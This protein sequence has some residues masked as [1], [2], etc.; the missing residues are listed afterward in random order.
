MNRFA[1]LKAYT[2]RY[3]PIYGTEDFCIYFY[4]L[5]KMRRPQRV[6]ELG[7]GIGAVAL[8]GALAL[9][10]NS[11][12]HLL[13]IDNGQ[14][15]PRLQQA[16]EP[17]NPFYRE[18]YV[19]Y[20]A[21][22][23]E[24]FQLPRLQFQHSTVQYQSLPEGIDILFSDYAHSPL[25]ILALLADVLPKMSS[26]SLIMIDSASTYYPS[27]A[28]LEQLVDEFNA[29]R[30]PT[31]LLNVVQ[32]Q[33]QFQER[34]RQ[35]QFSLQHLVEAKSRSQNSTAIISLQPRDLFPYPLTSMRFS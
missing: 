14:E 1:S 23:L 5:V 29:G 10:E 13:S 32:D 6:V 20:I 24:H 30:V 28:L 33:T 11:A 26:T 12:G 9:E 31:T 35:T 19:E 25:N 21:A 22:L 16:I 2:D 4:S 3:A 7:T 27:Y 34:V 15:W 8:W 17:D 18:D